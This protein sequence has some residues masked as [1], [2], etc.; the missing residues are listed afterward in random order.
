MDSSCKNGGVLPC[1]VTVTLWGGGGGGGGGAK[2]C[3]VRDN[4]LSLVNSTKF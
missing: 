3:D 4:V 2:C 1:V